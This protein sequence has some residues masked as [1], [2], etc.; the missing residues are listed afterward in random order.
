MI[1][2]EKKNRFE[3]ELQGIVMLS[4]RTKHQNIPEDQVTSTISLKINS[5]NNKQEK[6][7]SRSNLK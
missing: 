3:C 2:E 1:V 7:Y 5:I 4:F 6:K